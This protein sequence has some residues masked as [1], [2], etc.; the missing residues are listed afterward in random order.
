VADLPPIDYASGDFQTFLDNELAF[1]QAEL[2]QSDF[3]DFVASQI[4]M[5]LARLNAYTSGIQAF[6]LDITANEIFLVTATQRRSIIRFAKPLGYIMALPTAASV[7]LS[8]LLQAPYPQP[9]YITAGTQFQAGGKFWEVDDTYILQ[10]NT[11]ASIVRASNPTMTP[12]SVIGANEGQ[13]FTET[14]S[15]TGALNQQFVLTRSPIINNT[16]SMTVDGVPWTQIDYIVFAAATDKA[17]VVA[18]DENQAGTVEFGNSK[19]GLIPSLGS[20]IQ[21]TYRIGGGTAGDLSAG[22]INT[23]ILGL[24][25]N[26]TPVQVPVTNPTAA[27][28]GADAESIDHAKLYIPKFLKTIEHAVTIQDYNTLASVFSDPASGTVTKAITQLRGGELNK[29][30]VF[31]WVTDPVTGALVGGLNVPVALLNSLYD[32]LAVRNVLVH[33]LHVFAGIV[34]PVYIVANVLYQHNKTP[35]DVAA[36]LQLA[37]QGFFNAA[38][39]NPGEMVSISQL[40]E[41]FQLVD[42]VDSLVITGLDKVSSPVVAGNVAIDGDKIAVLGTA[43]FNLT[44]AP[45]VP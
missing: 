43:T 2:D 16:V 25:N 1:L 18:F 40:Y 10:A 32:Y 23:T 20:T 31:I 41:T 11:L 4:T 29:V 38:S 35:T 13:T 15:A 6:K 44:S 37:A 17:Y 19:Y 33:D 27:T 5:F 24:L 36:A 28:G 34:T 26:I 30:D 3:N 39:F 8:L 21:V 22:A 12:I 7:N 9:L 45:L 14:F 42:G